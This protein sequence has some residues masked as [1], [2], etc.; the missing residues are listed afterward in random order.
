[1]KADI[2]R[3]HPELEH[4]VD[5]WNTLDQLIEAAKEA[6]HAIDQGILYRLAIEM[7]NR[8]QAVIDA[9]GWYTKY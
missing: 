7:P 5:N 1:M 3:L 6:G 2:Y 9:E 8:V 4:A